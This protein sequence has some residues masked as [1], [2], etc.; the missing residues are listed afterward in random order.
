MHI[1]KMNDNK[2][3]EILNK[4]LNRFNDA[5]VSYRNDILWGKFK[6]SGTEL[7]LDTGDIETA[8]KLWNNSFTAL[9]TNNTLLNKEIQKGIYDDLIKGTASFYTGLDIRNKVKEIAFTLNALHGLRLVKIFKAKVSVELHTDLAHD[10]EGIEHF[11]TKLFNVDPGHFIIKVPF[12]AEGLIGARKLHD[13]GIPVN[14][15]LMF[16][17]RQNL[18]AALIAQPAFSNV[19]LGR[20]GAFL[21]NNDLGSSHFIGEF[22]TNETQKT[23]LALRKNDKTKTRLIAASI[24]SRE[25]LLHLKGTDVFTIPTSVVSEYPSCEVHL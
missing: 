9:T 4:L 11:G 23:L 13:K 18:L 19:F 5:E 16:S 14:F 20:I 25:Q 2:F 24:R 10:I 17:A 6:S 22:V 15:T 3:N 21:Q 1:G 7:W 12:T 8:R